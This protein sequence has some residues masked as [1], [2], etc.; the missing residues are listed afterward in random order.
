MTIQ[1][2]KYGKKLHHAFSLRGSTVNVYDEAL[3]FRTPGGSTPPRIPCVGVEEGVQD[4]NDCAVGLSG[5]S[6]SETTWSQS[7]ITPRSVYPMSLDEHSE[8]ASSITDPLDTRDYTVPGIGTGQF[9]P[10]CIPSSSEGWGIDMQWS[11]LNQ[12]DS[13]HGEGAFGLLAEP[14]DSHGGCAIDDPR[15]TGLR[16][17][18]QDNNDA[19]ALGPA[20]ASSPFFDSSD[21]NPMADFVAPTC[22]AEDNNNTDSF[23]TRTADHEVRIS[24]NESNPSHRPPSIVATGSHPGVEA[25][26]SP[27]DNVYTLDDIHLSND[28]HAR[29]RCKR[30]RHTQLRLKDEIPPRA[31][32]ECVY[33][34]AREHREWHAAMK[35]NR[36]CNA[37]EACLDLSAANT[38]CA[39]VWDEGR[40][41]TRPCDNWAMSPRIVVFTCEACN[42]TFAAGIS[43]AASY[44]ACYDCVPWTNLTVRIRDGYCVPRR[45]PP[46]I[47]VETS[48]KTRRLHSLYAARNDLIARI[49]RRYTQTAEHHGS[50]VAGAVVRARFKRSKTGASPYAQS[51]KSCDDASAAPRLLKYT[52]GGDIDAMHVGLRKPPRQPYTT[53]VLSPFDIRTWV[54]SGHATHLRPMCSS[55]NAAHNDPVCK[56]TRQR[57]NTAIWRAAQHLVRRDNNPKVVS[58]HVPGFPAES[59]DHVCHVAD[60]FKGLG[61]NVTITQA[62]SSAGDHLL[63]V[64]VFCNLHSLPN[65]PT[66]CPDH[67]TG[68][69]A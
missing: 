67:P 51:V 15:G 23:L 53:H 43:M 69:V 28:T 32:W 46:E 44:T 63:T 6:L 16:D 18:W 30:C 38:P 33:C 22:N 58:A 11:D 45:R 56:D 52:F 37:C 49:E 19:L 54:A 61:W 7:P 31:A 21:S 50:G 3:E 34:Y 8:F 20:I 42:G 55:L 62:R 1:T 10:T 41:F 66:H 35:Y 39:R 27:D 60:D 13:S 14:A 47:A 2:G 4:S 40:N 68:Q 36:P 59:Y 25:D 17:A 57:I 65:Q 12:S 29:V 24:A 9:T 26:V 48:R 64:F 5:E